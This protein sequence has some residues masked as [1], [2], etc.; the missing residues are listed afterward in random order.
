VSNNAI[1]LGK[2][3]KIPTPFIHPG[4]KADKPPDAYAKVAN[5]TDNGPL[6]LINYSKDDRWTV[7]TGQKIGYGSEM[8]L[9][10]KPVAIT[11]AKGITGTLSPVAE[12]TP[13]A[14]PPQ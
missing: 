14:D 7:S 4:A 5:E 9:G 8:K 11:F 13:A 6:F 1:S 2:G 3:S 10:E 12:P